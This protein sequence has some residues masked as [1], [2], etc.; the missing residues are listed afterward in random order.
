VEL[1]GLLEGYVTTK[2]KKPIDCMLVAVENFNL[3]IGERCASLA[4]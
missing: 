1:H 2:F 4:D 3:C